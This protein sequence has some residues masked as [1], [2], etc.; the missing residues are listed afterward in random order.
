[1]YIYKCIHINLYMNIYTEIT[2][3][4]EYGSNLPDDREIVKLIVVN[5]CYF[6]S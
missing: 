3:C 4:K 1:M 5:L 6:F 2:S